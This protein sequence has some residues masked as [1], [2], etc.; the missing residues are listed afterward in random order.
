MIKPEDLIGKSLEEVI[1]ILEE[2]SYIWRISRL[3]TFKRTDPP[4]RNKSRFNLEVEKG[5]VVNVT[6]G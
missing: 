2:N 5:N 4:T 3:Y 6:L 1:G